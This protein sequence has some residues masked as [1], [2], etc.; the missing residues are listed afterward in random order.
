[1]LK[2]EIGDYYYQIDCG[3]IVR[4]IDDEWG[5]GPQLDEYEIISIFNRD[6]KKIVEGNLETIGDFEKKKYPGYTHHVGHMALREPEAAL[7][8]R[9]GTEIKAAKRKIVFEMMSQ[10]HQKSEK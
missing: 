9:L 6:G 4:K 1:M 10:D 8:M 5:S 7:I 2:I 3:L